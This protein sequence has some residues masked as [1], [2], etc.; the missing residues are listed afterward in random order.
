LKSK[1]EEAFSAYRIPSLRELGAA[2]NPSPN[3]SKPRNSSRKL[4]KL[5]TSASELSRKL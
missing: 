4:Q 2:S 5:F 3:P 1:I